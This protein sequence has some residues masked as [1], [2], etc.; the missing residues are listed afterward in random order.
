MP[1]KAIK[2]KIILG[3]LSVFLL[4]ISATGCERKEGIGIG[5][6]GEAAKGTEGLIISFLRNFP[7]DSYLVGS[8]NEEISVAVDVRNKGT[9]PETSSPNGNIYLSGFDD[10]IITLEKSKSISGL[11]LPGV[12]SLNPEGGIDTIEFKGQ[13]ITNKIKV[14]KYEPTILATVC[15]EYVTKD[16]PSV[17]IDPKPF[18]ETQ[19]KVCQIGDITLASQ[20]APVAITKIDEEA[21]TNKIRFKI[22]IKNVGGGDIIKLNALGK[23]NPY[24]S[25]DLER[26]DFDRVV[27]GEVTV[28]SEKLSCEPL[29]EGRVIRLFNG[30]GFVIC[31]LDK[32]SAGSAYTTPLNIELGYGYRSTILKPIKISKITS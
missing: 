17:C 4:L 26:D 5:K 14:D 2:I 31:T 8:S 18:D 12:S 10:D 6:K 24:G 9:Y 27:L 20:G 1:K 29:A 25:A 15:Y 21:S 32:P 16:G 19:E 3:I 11:S 30:E 23:C 22:H 13:I 28:G 7:Q